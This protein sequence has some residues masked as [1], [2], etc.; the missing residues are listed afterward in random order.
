MVGVDLP[1]RA[2]GFLL[3]KEL[4]AFSTVLEEP[5]RPFLAILGGAKVRDKIPLIESL[6]DK[7]SQGVQERVPSLRAS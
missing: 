1:I 2:S 5:Q 6:L 3:Q 4:S 7:V